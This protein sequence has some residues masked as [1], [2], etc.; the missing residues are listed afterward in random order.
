MAHIVL[1]GDS[2]FDNKSYVSEGRDVISHL[3]QR[4]DSDSQASLLAV[5][6]ATIDN[7]RAQVS[8]IPEDGT[9]L[10]LSAGGNDALGHIDILSDQAQT[11]ADALLT[12]ARIRDKFARSYRGLIRSIKEL[13]NPLVVCTIYN[14]PM[15]E[16]EMQ[17]VV[18]LGLSLFNDTILGIA[19]EESLSVIE[20]RLICNEESDFESTIEPSDSGGGK[21]AEAIANAVS[22]EPTLP[23]SQV[24]SM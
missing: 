22:I 4:L 24:F 11:V 18:E 1:L 8:Q 13:R 17:P 20:M 16:D 15:F 5:D 21:I 12:L 3:H 19:F 10:V 9:H 23:R 2:I 14:P 6:G 7:M